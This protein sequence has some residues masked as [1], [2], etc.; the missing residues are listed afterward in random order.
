MIYIDRPFGIYV[1]Y[2]PIIAGGSIQEKA[3]DSPIYI[4]S[5]A[6]NKMNH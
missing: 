3:T 6:I 2:R 5:C 4:V 1:G